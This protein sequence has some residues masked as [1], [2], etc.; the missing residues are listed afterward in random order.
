MIDIDPALLIFEK[1]NFI[2]SVACNNENKL[3][4]TLKFTSA[5]VTF[6]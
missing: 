3:K 2:L 1:V 6:N 4:E 5:K